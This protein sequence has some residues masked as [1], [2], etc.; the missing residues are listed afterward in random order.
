[1]RSAASVT[2][3]VKSTSAGD[4]SPPYDSWTETVTGY[5]KTTDPPFPS[6]SGGQD[7]ITC[8]TLATC[9]AYYLNAEN[10]PLDVSAVGAGKQGTW[11]V[12]AQ[13]SADLGLPGWSA[14]IDAET[15]APVTVVAGWSCDHCYYLTYSF[16]LTPR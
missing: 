7:P 6:P 4:A 11:L 10:Y 5:G 3:T 14:T 8:S 15:Y 9:A 13:G 1:F 12:Q 16:H 2:V